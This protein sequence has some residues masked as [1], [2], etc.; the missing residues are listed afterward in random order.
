MAASQPTTPRE[1]TFKGWTPKDPEKRG[2][3]A[4][5][6]KIRD[7]VERMSIVTTST[8]KD[9]VPGSKSAPLN[10]GLAS[11]QQSPREPPSGSQ[12]AMPHNILPPMH[13]P[14]HG[15]GGHGGGHHLAD[16]RT[17]PLSHSRRH[18]EESAFARQQQPYYQAQ[19]QAQHRSGASGSASN[20]SASR[21]QQQQQDP[22][23]DP[24][25]PP[26]LGPRSALPPTTA[27][28]R[29]FSVPSLQQQHSSSRYPLSPHAPPGPPP[30]GPPLP[31]PGPGPSSARPSNGVSGHRANGYS[32]SPSPPNHLREQFL[33][34]FSQLYDML[35]SVDGLRYQLQD[36]I[37]RTEQAYQNQMQANNEFKST[38][39]Q[40]SSL[41]G[42]L[43]QSADSLKEM[44]R[45]EVDRSAGADRRE[46][47]EL[48]DR[49]RS[50][51][52]RLSQR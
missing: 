13:Y 30:P 22:R 43:Q 25:Y 9:V 1:L 10:Q 44:V 8:D 29:N 41:L 26:D 42:T 12:T 48:R 3:G 50:L 27:D 15:H 38:A 28:R 6:E 40:A 17:A 7:K 24:R 5:R 18:H 46:V 32:V 39:A 11:Q 2:V 21:S 19:Q 34:P 14:S 23:G 35:S 36:M 37:H 51:E 31:G 16:L 4:R 47:D 45:Y 49:V 33:A 52:D 20:Q